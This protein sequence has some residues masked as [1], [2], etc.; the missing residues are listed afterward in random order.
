MK[1]IAYITLLCGLLHGIATAQTLPAKFQVYCPEY[2]MKP[3]GNPK[4]IMKGQSWQN[5][6][7][8]K[9]RN[10]DFGKDTKT[11]WT[12]YS[13]RANNQTYTSSSSSASAYST[14]DF[15]D[16]LFVAK[17]ENGYALVFTDEYKNDKYPNIN[18]TA[19][20]KGWIPV[21]N[22][23][24]WIEC[25]KTQSQIYQKAL[26]VHDPTKGNATVE[27]NP[28]Y[29][30]APKQNA[31]INPNQRAKDLDILF[32]MKTADVG[33]VR[34]YL[35]SKEMNCEKYEYVIYGWMSE[36]YVTEWDHRL[37]LEPTFASQSVRD[38]QN[39]HIG[40]SIFSDIN[41]AQTLYS[42]GRIDNPLWSYDDFKSGER[43]DSYIIRNPIISEASTS[44]FKVA[45]I[46]SLG[47]TNTKDRADNTKDI[48][49]MKEL[50]KNINVIFVID[51]TNSMKKYYPSVA[52]ALSDI[53]RRDFSTNIKVGAVLYKDYKDPDCITYKPVTSEINEIIGFITTANTGSIAKEHPEAMFLGIE[54]ALDLGKMR[55]NKDHGNFIILI[56]DA[57]NHRDDP[58]YEKKWQDIIPNLASK[59]FDNKINF[60]AYQVN[61]Y[62]GDAA[63][64]DFAMQVGKL[65]KELANKIQ[66]RI[67][68][69]TLE[70]EP[71]SNRFYSLTRKGKSDEELPVY[72]SYKYASSGKSETTED[73]KNI[74]IE[75]ITD[76]EQFIIDRLKRLVDTDF[77]TTTDG[78][79][80]ETR[81]REILRLYDWSESRIENYI[82]YL[83][84]D[85][86]AKFLGYAA[87]KTSASKY[88]LFDY[89]LFFSQNELADLIQQLD[90]LNSPN[91]SSSKKAFQDA[92]ISIGQAMI[93][94][95]D[96]TDFRSKTIEELLGQIYGVPI[97]MESCGIRIDKIV[98][99]EQSEVDNY[100]RMFKDK[101]Q[102][103]KTIK[104]NSYNGR[105][106]SNG[107]A[108][109]WIPFSDM[110]GFCESK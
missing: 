69:G 101:L 43:M 108:Y 18:S 95:F 60:L 79:L 61:N 6:C 32:I 104:N 28:F 73:L 63:Y 38:Y 54:T 21:E 52:N 44:I 48:E 109:Y 96:A 85:G 10:N 9:I 106:R 26:I 87:E 100:I 67:K 34:Y 72:D 12:V 49:R 15:M 27:K 70:F 103:L 62:A 71:K 23:L 58:H 20:S 17:I 4:G 31:S 37:L 84:Q 30:L 77:G 65:Q 56:G 55:Y 102:G 47:V 89:V 74:I 40:P 45:A 107:L 68:S 50:Q 5:W 51:A 88:K 83:K 19:Q 105:F 57:G 97:K 92:L 14:L 39:R 66:Y 16:K 53:M 8:S 36:D 13:D 98:S 59:M 1:N 99:M 42:N 25:P 7:V 110:P 22:L 76:F 29:L 93:G 81:L 41:Q 94:Q 80:K 82:K 33:G 2:I 24:L 86:S 91:V 78:N 35:L 3:E 11:A 46:S 64:N 75:N 90:K